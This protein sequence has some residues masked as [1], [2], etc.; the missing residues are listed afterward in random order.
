MGPNTITISSSNTRP[1]PPQDQD[2][3]TLAT[4]SHQAKIPKQQENAAAATQ[5]TIKQ[6]SIR[7]I[8][9]IKRVGNPMHFDFEAVARE[10]NAQTIARVV[11]FCRDS[12]EAVS[13]L[14]D[15]SVYHGSKL[16]GRPSGTGFVAVFDEND[17]T[18]CEQVYLGHFSHGKA[19]K[20][21]YLVFDR[22]QGR[23]TGEWYDGKYHGKG[24][25]KREWPSEEDPA[26]METQFYDGQW[27]QGD[28]SGYGMFKWP[29]GNI[30]EGEWLAN[31]RHGQGKITDSM[32][33]VRKQGRW[34]MG[35]FQVASQ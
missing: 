33:R 1:Q 18:I 15:G 34:Q 30:Y 3:V 28:M 13:H 35:H 10:S 12:P 21:G 16:D 7:S 20:F 29:S 25:F 32:G 9:E 8:K 4:A 27:Q 19:S 11:A 23:Y 2:E 22:G 26:K 24:L 5:K 17:P 6:T 31:R 14:G